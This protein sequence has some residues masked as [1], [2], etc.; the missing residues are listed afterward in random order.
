ME[1]NSDIDQRF[2]QM[3][4]M[5]QTAVVGSMSV[6]VLFWRQV[7]ALLELGRTRLPIRESN[8]WHKQY[9]LRFQRTN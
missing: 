9:L 7:A 8:L 3:M 6:K 4:M 5:K 1:Y 2:N